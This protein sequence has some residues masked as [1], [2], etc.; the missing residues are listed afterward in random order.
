MKVV[1]TTE[2]LWKMMAQLLVHCESP[3]YLP[4]KMSTNYM[5]ISLFRRSIAWLITHHIIKNQVTQITENKHKGY[6]RNKL[7]QTLKIQSTSF[8]EYRYIYIQIMTK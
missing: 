1:I 8:K 3:I 2:L 6:C 7:Y 4:S 5:V